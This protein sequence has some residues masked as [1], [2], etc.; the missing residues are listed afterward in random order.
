MPDGSLAEKLDALFLARGDASLEDVAR[1]IRQSG[2]PTVSASYLWL[3]RTGKK[4]NPT[5]R[6]VEALARHFGV[7]G[8]PP[9]YFFDDALTEQETPAPELLAALRDPEVRVL[10]LR[11]TGLSALGRQA[12]SE[13]A[14]QLGRIEAQAS[15]RRTG[16]TPRR[17]RGAA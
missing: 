17:R 11:A 9:A 5:L 13:L 2:G 12:L 3:L 14:V 15:V 10:A 6:H 1:A 8:V 7:P 16:G 4:D